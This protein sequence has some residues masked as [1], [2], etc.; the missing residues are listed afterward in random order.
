MHLPKILQIHLLNTRCSL[1]DVRTSHGR[2]Q[3]DRADVLLDENHAM[4]LA[5][6]THHDISSER[7]MDLLLLFQVRGGVPNSTKKKAK[8]MGWHLTV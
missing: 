3:K 4:N 6:R 8:S 2:S 5:C 7:T 1:C